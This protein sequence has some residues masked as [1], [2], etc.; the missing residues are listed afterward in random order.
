MF[1][2]HHNKK[3]IFKR[4]T[5]NFNKIKAAMV[6][7]Q[8]LVVRYKKNDGTIDGNDNRMNN[9]NNYN[10]NILMMTPARIY[11]F[12][13]SNSKEKDKTTATSALEQLA[14]ID[15]NSQEGK[16]CFSFSRDN[17]I[18]AQFF[19]DS[20]GVFSFCIVIFNFLFSG[21]EG[22]YLFYLG[23]SFIQLLLWACEMQ[24]SA[25]LSNWAPD[26]AKARLRV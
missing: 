9:K 22:Y 23:S 25:L 17:K 5:A 11:I 13:T 10:F 3:H 20:R 8:V 12:Q 18:K 7:S 2:S 21:K 14:A 1:A 19:Q 16:V 15:D 26:S 6:F 24:L 4:T